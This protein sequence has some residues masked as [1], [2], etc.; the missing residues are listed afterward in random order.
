MGSYMSE[1]TNPPD[2]RRTIREQDGR[3][4]TCG[5]SYEEHRG[6]RLTICR[7]MKDVAA[8]D[9]RIAELEASQDCNCPCAACGH[10]MSDDDA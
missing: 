10:C 9:A 6:D 8:K 5:Y 7:M 3:C 2:D 1:P 4:G